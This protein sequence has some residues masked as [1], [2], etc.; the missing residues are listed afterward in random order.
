VETIRA[1]LSKRRP[2]DG[3]SID[4]LYSNQVIEHLPGTDHFL[5]ERRRVVR[6]ADTRSSPRTTFRA[7]TTP[8][9][10]SLPL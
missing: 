5:K 2:I 9:R 8:R 3:E 6:Q 10:W 7:G 1:D 4:I